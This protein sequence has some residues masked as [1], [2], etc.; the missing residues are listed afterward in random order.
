MDKQGVGRSYQ[1]SSI[2][3][4]PLAAL[5]SSPLTLL[6]PS[7]VGVATVTAEMYCMSRYTIDIGV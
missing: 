4:A 6:I 3:G 7:L 5:L 1:A 2:I